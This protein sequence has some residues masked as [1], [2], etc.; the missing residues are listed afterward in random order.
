MSNFFMSDEQ[1]KSFAKTI[2]SEISL[3][4]QEHQEE[5][6]EFLREEAINE[7]V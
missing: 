7:G 2:F 3:Y 1:I 6:E 4:I 5:Y